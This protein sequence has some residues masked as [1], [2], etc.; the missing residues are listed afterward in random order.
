[1]ATTST[2]TSSSEAIVLSK[3]ALLGRDML[4]TL[5]THDHG[6]VRAMAR[7][8]KTL[9]SRRAPHLQTGNLITVAL[10]SRGNLFQ[11]QETKLISAFSQLKAEPKK[12]E[13]LYLFFFLLDRLLPEGEGEEDVY[14][15]TKQYLV[16]LSRNDNFTR[17]RLAEYWSQ[18]L[19]V[20]GYIQEPKRLMELVATTQELINDRIPL[21]IS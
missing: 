20:L 3:K 8:V 5:F 7:G 21:R 18:L 12:V 15:L 6:K 2:R 19:M 10:S 17:D 1:M 13:Y 14:T 16:D 9:T 11:I 4:V